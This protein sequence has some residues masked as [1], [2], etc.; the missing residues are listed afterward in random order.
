MVRKT[1]V[2]STLSFVDLLPDRLAADRVEPRGR[3]VQEQHPRLVDER[4]GQV[5]APAHAARVGPDL[6]VR[7]V[8][9]VDALEQ[10][11]GPAASLVAREPVERRLEADQL[12]PGHQRIER[13]LLERDADRAAHAAA[14]SATTS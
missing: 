4:R 13:R 8:D 10:R 9:Q 1:V 3:L 12:P 14:A 5:Q 6:A 7:G 11:I 2:P